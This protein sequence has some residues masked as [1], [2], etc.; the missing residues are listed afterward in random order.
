MKKIL[1]KQKIA[2]VLLIVIFFNI[3]FVN[4][5]QADSS[6]VDFERNDKGV[7]L[8][9]ENNTAEKLMKNSEYKNGL[10]DNIFGV[11]GNFFLTGFES[12]NVSGHVYGN[13]L[14][15]KF[16]NNVNIGSGF[17]QEFSYIEENWSGNNLSLTKNNDAILVLGESFNIDYEANMWKI[18]N[19]K[20]NSPQKNGT[21]N[22]WQDNKR[23]FIDLQKAKE[24]MIFLS[25]NL[26][27]MKTSD[28]F[29][30]V[31]DQNELNRINMNGVKKAIVI[32]ETNK[33]SYVYNTT[34][35][36]LG[37]DKIGFTKLIKNNQT[38][39]LNIDTKGKSTIQLPSIVYNYNGQMSTNTERDKPSPGNIIVNVFDSTKA[40]KVFNGKIT[41]GAENNIFL[42]SPNADVEISQQMNGL[43]IAN[44][45]K[46]NG[47]EI[48][49]DRP[50]TPPI[51]P[52]PIEYLNISIEKSW[53]DINGKDINTIIDSNGKE[54]HEITFLL[55]NKNTNQSIR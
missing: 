36:D 19:K 13:V 44:T 29:K 35:D 7:V 48:H 49:R 3:L 32:P 23:K 54:I 18:N 53:K 37:K 4:I 28:G 27:N 30:I 34:I 46:N 8:V 6:K 12:V 43:V 10:V 50:T 9:N 42:L 45:I 40:D 47:T 55:Y 38:I 21:D 41:T 24:D 22:L 16:N 15:K 5:T 33:D 26:S 11:L 14:T 20:I 52:D 39:F 2:S 25:N 31:T 51:T 17:S 1:N